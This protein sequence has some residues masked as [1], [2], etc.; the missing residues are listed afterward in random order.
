MPSCRPEAVTDNVELAASQLTSAG[1]A[2]KEARTLSR[3]GG[4]LDAADDHAS[5]ADKTPSPDDADRRVNKGRLQSPTRSARFSVP[6]THL[7]YADFGGA[8]SHSPLGRNL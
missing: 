2:P 7:A 6:P 5:S 3:S 1:E 8:P 4:E